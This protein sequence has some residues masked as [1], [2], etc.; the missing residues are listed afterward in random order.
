MSTTVSTPSPAPSTSDRRPGAAISIR[1]V[2]KSYGS[3]TVLDGLDLEIRGGEFMTLL[4][5]SGSGKST[6][7]NV[8][9]G[10]TGATSGTIEVDG[11]PL[12]KVPA[13]KRGFGVVFQNY[14]LFPHMSVA[15]NVA[16]PLRRQRRGKAET[17]K[18]V[19][20]A[21]E[22]VELGHLGKRR[23][24][25]LS[26]GQRQRVAFARAVVFQPSV[27]LMDEPLSALDKL[28]REQLQLEIRRLHRELGITFIFVTHDQDEALAMSDRIALLRGG[29]IVQVGTPEELYRKP[30]S[31]FTAEFIGASNIF[32]G[33]LGPDGF[34]DPISGGFR[35]AD[36]DGQG[37]GPAR[38]MLRPERISVTARE[39]P[40]PSHHDFITGTVEDSVYFGNC[41]QVQILDAYGRHIIART[42]VPHAPDGVVPGA[43][44]NLSWPVEDL[45]VLG[46]KA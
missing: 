25:E 22:M 4:G 40:V 29:K 6:L 21:L 16:F 44:V 35:V 46:D 24:D 23:P 5:S 33:T 1:G 8:I 37:H 11:R 15:D 41:R 9:A 45:V 10:F 12:N 28:L 7:L 17:R 26:G 38:V 14:S 42:P 3:N 27:L 34:H 13:H 19:A 32:E 20:D 31:Q 43:A 18:A 39:I 2:G 30:N 36:T